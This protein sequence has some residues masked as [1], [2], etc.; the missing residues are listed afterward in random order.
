VPPP[1]LGAHGEQ[2]AVD[3]LTD[4]G[5]RVLDR[6][7]RCREGELDVVARE[8]RALVFCEVKTRRG[9]GFGSP[10][11]AVTPAKQRRIRVLAQRWLAAHDEHAPEIRFDVVGVLV[12]RAAPPEVTHLR[13][14]FS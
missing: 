8:G 2:L 4:E 5:L 6:N 13:A 14:A 12:H 11:E 1:R 9:L 10:A 3:F 7:W